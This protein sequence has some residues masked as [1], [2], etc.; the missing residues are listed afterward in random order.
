MKHLLLLL[1]IS[2]CAFRS[3]ERRLCD[4]EYVVVQADRENKIHDV[5]VLASSGKIDWDE[6][7]DLKNQ[8]FTVERMTKLRCEAL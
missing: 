7:L 8:I 4:A 1:T 5:R 6:E 2:S 3:E